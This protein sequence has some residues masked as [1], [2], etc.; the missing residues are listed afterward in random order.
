MNMPLFGGYCEDG[1]PAYKRLSH[2]YLNK[3]RLTGLYRCHLCPYRTGYRSSIRSHYAIHSSDRPYG[4]DCC[5]YKAKRA[6]DLRKHK[7][8]K[9]GLKVKRRSGFYGHVPTNDDLQTPSQ[10]DTVGPQQNLQDMSENY[11]SSANTGLGNLLADTHDAVIRPVFPQ[12]DVE[13]SMQAILG[14]ETM[15]DQQTP[16]VV[17]SEPEDIHFSPSEPGQSEM[18]SYCEMDRSDTWSKSEI[19]QCRFSQSSP[20]QGFSASSTPLSTTSCQPSSYYTMA[21]STTDVTS[22]S[23]SSHTSRDQRASAELTSPDRLRPRSVDECSLNSAS[24][25]SS[26]ETKSACTDSKKSFLC[27]HCNIMFFDPAI[28]FMHKGLH[29]V[30]NPWRCNLCGAMMH[31][32]YSFTSHF[33][34][35]HN[36]TG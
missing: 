1:S 5:P 15:G 12:S 13:A 3:D 9:H 8:L 23:T 10:H 31:D 33:I 35:G 34:N 21:Q 27:S 17:K 11:V 36:T 20:N 7:L 25:P 18:G 32:V 29:D 22:H 19:K 30:T 28:Y 14:Q 4:C 26:S 6:S 24:V 16:I 2:P